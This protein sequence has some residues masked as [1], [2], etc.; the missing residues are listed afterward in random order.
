MQS[1]VEI[2]SVKKDLTS[3]SAEKTPSKGKVVEEFSTEEKTIRK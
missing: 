2:D 3:F 1:D